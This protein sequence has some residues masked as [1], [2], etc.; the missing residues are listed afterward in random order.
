MGILS[1]VALPK[2]IAATCSAAKDCPRIH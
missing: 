1:M 2:L